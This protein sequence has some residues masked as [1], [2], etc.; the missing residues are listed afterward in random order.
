MGYK[1]Q[2]EHNLLRKELYDTNDVGFEVLAVVSLNFW[3][4]ILYSLS[5]EFMELYSRRWNS[6]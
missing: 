5:S 6:L 1:K 2:Y 4:I 3:D